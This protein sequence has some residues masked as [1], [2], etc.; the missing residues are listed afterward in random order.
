MRGGADGYVLEV[1]PLE[2]QP[3]ER[4]KPALP[5]SFPGVV[6]PAVVGQYGPPS[7]LYL[8]L[9]FSMK[10][11]IWPSS[12]RSSVCRRCHATSATFS[13][14]SGYGASAT[15]CRF[16]VAWFTTPTNWLTS[17]VQASGQL[18]STQTPPC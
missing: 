3:R 2:T 7:G 10:L 5:A 8:Q 12:K 18:Y 11:V 4:L 6:A 1:L 13:S 16:C 14:M 15:G 9:S 17:S